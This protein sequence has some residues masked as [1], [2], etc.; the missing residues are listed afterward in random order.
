MMAGGDRPNNTSNARGTS[1]TSST[2]S[3]RNLNEYDNTLNQVPI[4]N[5]G[6][7]WVCLLFTLSTL[8]NKPLMILGII[9]YWILRILYG[10]EQL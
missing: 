9:K 1:G 7:L 8:T 10:I 4:T 5:V 3:A 6:R 2:S